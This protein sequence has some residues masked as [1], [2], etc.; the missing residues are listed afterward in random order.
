MTSREKHQ[1]PQHNQSDSK[2]TSSSGTAP[3]HT[4]N[5][6]PTRNHEATLNENN[7]DD[8]DDAH[9]THTS[10]SHETRLLSELAVPSMIVKIGVMVPQAI[11][12]ATVGRRFGIAYL[13]GFTLANFVINIFTLSIVQ[14]LLSA[15]DTLAP[16]AFGADNPG[17]VG[18]LAIRGTIVCL[19]LV[20]PVNIV[21]S[22]FLESTFLALGQPAMPSHYAAE[23][24]RVYLFGMPFT[25]L[26]YVLWKF[27]A[28]QS[29][30]KPLVVVGLVSF[31]VTLPLS[32]SVLL[33]RYGFVGA[34]LALDVYQVSQ[35]MLLLAYLAYFQPHRP[36][37]WQGGW[38][39]SIREAL[40]VDAIQQYVRLGVGGILAMGQWWFFETLNILVGHLG[41]VPLS[42][43][44][45]A[46]QVLQA[47][48]MIP[49]GLAY[50]LS[51]RIGTLLAHNHERARK[52]M[53]VCYGVFITGYA[54]STIALYHW[55]YTIIGLFLSNPTTTAVSRLHSGACW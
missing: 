32:L 40:R 14:G 21:L 33:N 54:I 11:V 2:D 25:I 15:T 4:T 51:V 18:I 43:H 53:I 8:D 12:A 30:M 28:A 9:L 47:S 46:S 16:Q 7:D 19:V 10:C 17:E 38:S 29:S 41:T 48:V 50:G 44:T 52:L 6:G 36:A 27:L 34:A 31:C 13:D 20:M 3:I 39:K 37:T 49:T 24:Y 1:R 23:Y 42:V 35:S 55:R 22:C 45:I 26:Y 5:E